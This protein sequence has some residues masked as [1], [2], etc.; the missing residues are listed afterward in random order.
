MAGVAEGDHGVNARASA[1]LKALLALTEALD[2][3]DLR[4]NVLLSEMLEHSGS[5]RVL[6][7]GVVKRGKST[8][9]NQLL[10]LAASPV[11][12]LPETAGLIAYPSTSASATAWGVDSNGV[13]R[14]LPAGVRRF[15]RQ[16]SRGAGRG[17]ELSVRS[18]HYLTPTGVT[19]VDT[20]GESEASLDTGVPAGGVPEDI[21]RTATGVIVVFGV[22]GV[23]ATDVDLLRRVLQV[24]SSDPASVVLVIKSLDAAV[25]RSDLEDFR[26]ELQLV[27]DIAPVAAK[28]IVVSEG[29][30]PALD[31]IRAWMTRQNGLSM[32]R[33]DQ[34]WPIELE[35]EL[36]RRRS[37]PD[38]DPGQGVD[39]SEKTIT[40]LPPELQE[41]VRWL[42]PAAIAER[43][44]SQIRSQYEAERLAFDG[45][46][47]NWDAGCKPL[48]ERLA[49]L[50]R[51]LAGVEG[52]IRE[53]KRGGLAPGILLLVALPFSCVAFPFGPIAVGI[54][55]WF[56]SDARAVQKAEEV[57]PLETRVTRLSEQI[58]KC[59]EE[60]AIHN[61]LQPLAPVIP[62]E[63][64]ESTRLRRWCQRLTSTDPRLRH[65]FAGSASETA[66]GLLRVTAS[67]LCGVILLYGLAVFALGLMA[68]ITATRQSASASAMGR[69]EA[70]PP[71]VKLTDALQVRRIILKDI[72]F[73]GLPTGRAT[74][75][76]EA[77]AFFA[78][79]IGVVLAVSTL[80]A[81]RALVRSPKGTG[82][83]E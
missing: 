1:Q 63:L 16:V 32:S 76:S 4:R 41:R 58:S 57:R 33:G 18:S 8:L 55:M 20:V 17:L 9:V 66:L 15:R 5:R 61:R 26:E 10:G 60:I 48:A 70:W 65:A 53:L 3:T 75:V 73:Y 23:S 39:L 81:L 37:D 31:T 71:L 27:D 43:H 28:A 77:G 19:L 59:L 50:E 74:F 21:V 11:H 72:S 36:E 78:C 47:A 62:N 46:Y 51:D 80:L 29:D 68:P 6:V 24:R 22:P 79:S 67:G 54:A 25:S 69:A 82:S 7:M 45:Q 44:I 38:P 52:R 56:W 12:L 30:D 13:T 49:R 35:T 40:D 34:G 83:A 2:R 42:A 14:R 64:R